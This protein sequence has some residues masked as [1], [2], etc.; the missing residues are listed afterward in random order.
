MDVA[1]AKRLEQL[2]A[3]N[4][5]LKKFLAERIRIGRMGGLLRVGDLFHGRSLR[6][7]LSPRRRSGDP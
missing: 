3:E 1:D 6:S 2:E 5:R 7:N 4:V